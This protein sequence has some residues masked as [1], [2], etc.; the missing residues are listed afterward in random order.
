[1]HKDDSDIGTIEID[2]II[3]GNQKKVKVDLQSVE[4]WE[5][6]KAHKTGN[7][8]ECKGDL[9]L[10]ARSAKLI[11]LTN[12]KVVVNEDFFDF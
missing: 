7:C 6:H 5:A 12:F 10:S 11:N 1:M 9:I 8:I 2:T 3:D 4:Y